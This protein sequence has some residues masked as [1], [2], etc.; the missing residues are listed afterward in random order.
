MIHA[1]NNGFYLNQR[2]NFIDYFHVLFTALFL[3]ENLSTF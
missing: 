1:A 2:H 3:I